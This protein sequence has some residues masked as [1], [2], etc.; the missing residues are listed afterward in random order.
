MSELLSSETNLPLLQNTQ[1]LETE[2]VLAVLRMLTRCARGPVVRECL[3]E[4]CA[5]IAFLVSSEGEF[6]EF[7]AAEEKCQE[8]G[9][10]EEVVCDH[11]VESQDAD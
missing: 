2:D 5:E 7:L 9:T 11:V 6:E 3:R 4:V 10:V 1:E 8:D